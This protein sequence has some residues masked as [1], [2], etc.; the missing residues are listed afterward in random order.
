MLKII[1]STP[2]FLQAKSVA[3]S[4]VVVGK[5]NSPKHVSVHSTLPIHH[6]FCYHESAGRISLSTGRRTI[7]RESSPDKMVNRNIGI[8]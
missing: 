4:L 3:A 1:Q 8:K 2:R 6:S 5:S 7:E